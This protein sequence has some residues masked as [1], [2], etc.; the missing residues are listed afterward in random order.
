[1]ESGLEERRPDSQEWVVSL[2]TRGLRGR[3]RVDV[4]PDRVPPGQYVTADFPVLSACPTPVFSA[5]EWRFTVTGRD[6]AAGRSSK[7]FP[8]R[9]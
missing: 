7:R 9:R 8:A 3:R 6:G 4:P 1:M 5:D 2:V